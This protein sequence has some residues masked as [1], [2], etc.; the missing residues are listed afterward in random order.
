MHNFSNEKPPKPPVITSLRSALNEIDTW[1]K[2]NQYERIFDLEGMPWDVKLVVTQ[3][4]C[5]EDSRKLT[6][7]LKIEVSTNATADNFISTGTFDVVE[8]ERLLALIGDHSVPLAMKPISY[9]ANSED[10][11]RQIIANALPRLKANFP[12]NSLDDTKR[13]LVGR[14]I[15]ERGVFGAQKD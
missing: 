14:W 15:D 4:A 5:K 13:S 12:K 2:E 1:Q 10:E 8:D 9:V 3:G 6:W 7:N 11:A